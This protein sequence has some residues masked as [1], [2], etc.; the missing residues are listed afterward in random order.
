MFLLAIGLFML[1]YCLGHYSFGFSVL[2]YPGGHHG[3]D[4]AMRRQALDL[5]AAFSIWPASA[6]I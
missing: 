5:R 6:H 1:L 2:K 3:F 4:L